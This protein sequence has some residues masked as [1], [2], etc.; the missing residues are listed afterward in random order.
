MKK[1]VNIVPSIC[2]V[3]RPNV[4]KS[5]LFNQLVGRRKAVVIEES[6]TTRDRVEAVVNINSYSFKIVDTGG[7]LENDIDELSSQVK[8]QIYMAVKEASLVVMVTDAIDGIVPADRQVADILRKTGQPVILA[9]NKAD[10]KKFENEAVEFY[11]FGFG[12]PISISCL[13]HKG[14]KE[15]K[16]QIVVSATSLLDHSRPDESG[17][18]KIAVVGRPNVGKSSFVNYLLKKERVIVSDIPGTTRDSIDSK[19]T[20][21]GD[22]Y[23]LIDTAGIRHKRKIKSVVD[24]FSMMRSKESIKRADV[25]MLLL[26]AADGMTSDDSGIID[27]IEESGKA[28][29]VFVNKWDLAKEADGVTVEEY[30]RQIVYASPRLRIFPILFISALTGKGV[31]KSLS[32]A[33]VLDANLDQKAATPVLNKLFQDNNPLYIPIPRRKK[34]PNFLYITQTSCRPIEFTYF[35]NNPL[36]V[37]PVHLNFIENVLR[38][39]LSL[40]GLA[41]KVNVKGTR[42]EK[43]R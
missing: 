40:K 13:H 25:V 18:I 33:R 17:S 1:H 3:G 9:V 19:F 2:I 43:K 30:E 6:G 15:L 27:L 34:R 11:A 4:G 38:D 22:E 41:I 42:K 8:D 23:I 16:K 29:I 35:V 26:D 20:H 7:Y 36:T 5:S 10:N 21:D 24:T 28:C 39:N 37:L 14:L 31:L 32:V 12:T